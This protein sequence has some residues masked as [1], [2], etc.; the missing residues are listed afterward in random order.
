MKKYNF[1][2]ENNEI[3][4]FVKMNF[5]RNEFSVINNDEAFKNMYVNYITQ[6]NNERW[7]K[8]C[9]CVVMQMDEY[10]RP[11]VKK[12][13]DDYSSNESVMMIIWALFNGITTK[14]LLEIVGY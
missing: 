5:N 2:H 12:F 11:W 10:D 3:K 6:P 13:I 14:E 8:Y 7:I 9:E 1:P 4:N